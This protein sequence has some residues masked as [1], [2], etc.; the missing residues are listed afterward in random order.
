MAGNLKT[1]YSKMMDSS[2][3]RVSI[4]M[5]RRVYWASRCTI[6]HSTV[7]Y[8]IT[9]FFQ[10]IQKTNLIAD[11]R[12][13]EDC[14]IRIVVMYKVYLIKGTERGSW[15]LYTRTIVKRV[16]LKNLVLYRFNAPTHN[17]MYFHVSQ[18]T[19]LK[20]KCIWQTRQLPKRE[21]LEKHSIS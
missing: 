10:L 12:F 3:L 19:L 4:E 16:Q 5:R 14:A 18:N 17:A 8:G 9:L 15:K 2:F 6:Q 20:Q 13:N 21:Q 7:Q 11:W 1:M